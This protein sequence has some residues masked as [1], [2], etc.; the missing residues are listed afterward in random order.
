MFEGIGSYSMRLYTGVLKWEKED[1]EA[2][3][4]Q[5]QSILKDRSVHIYTMVHFVYGQKPVDAN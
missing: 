1:V 3:L 5:V 2:L 4:A